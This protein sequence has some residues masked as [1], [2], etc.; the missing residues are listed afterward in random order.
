MTS[1]RVSV[2]DSTHAPF[3]LL[4]RII[5]LNTAASSNIVSIYVVVFKRVILPSKL[6]LQISK[7]RSSSV[8]NISCSEQTIPNGLS[9][10]SKESFLWPI[11][12]LPVNPE[13]VLHQWH[14]Y[15]MH[16]Y[17]VTRCLVLKN[18]P[19]KCWLI[20]WNVFSGWFLIGLHS[21]SRLWVQCN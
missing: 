17:K 6:Y 12:R 8:R 2:S 19:R 7:N 5:W 13:S 9:W 16:L 4:F 18:C 15:L 1:A 21:P 3:S 14:A 10:S 20:L 11:W